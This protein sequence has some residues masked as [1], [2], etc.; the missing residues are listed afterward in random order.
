VASVIKYLHPDVYERARAWGFRSPCLNREF[1]GFGLPPKDRSQTKLRH[2]D[3]YSRL[4]VLSLL[5]KA[6]RWNPSKDISDPWKLQP[7]AEA[8]LFAKECTDAD[9]NLSDKGK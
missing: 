6:T 5:G 8:Y 2:L 7:T 3:A 1:G 9:W 4:S